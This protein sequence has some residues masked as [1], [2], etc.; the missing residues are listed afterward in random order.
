MGHRQL[1]GGHWPLG[2]IGHL[3]ATQ[4]AGGGNRKEEL[5]GLKAE[6]GQAG[7]DPDPAQGVAG[8]RERRGGYGV[9]SRT[10]PFGSQAADPRPRQG[11]PTLE[12]GQV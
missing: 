7:K 3:R 11:T 4:A 2:G 6:V 5:G 10:A 12:P 9:R 8:G 1:D